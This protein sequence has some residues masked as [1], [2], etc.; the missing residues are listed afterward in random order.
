MKYPL[1]FLYKNEGTIT[2]IHGDDNPRGPARIVRQIRKKAP[3]RLAVRDTVG[4]LEVV[5]CGWGTCFLTKV[6]ERGEEVVVYV[7]YGT[8]EERALVRHHEELLQLR[9]QKITHTAKVEILQT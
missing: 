9:L 2:V 3:S 1:V 6:L 8:G 7:M 4:D 5:T